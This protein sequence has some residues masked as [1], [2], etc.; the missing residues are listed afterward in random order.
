MMWRC[1]NKLVKMVT[2]QNG[3]VIGKEI[4]PNSAVPYEAL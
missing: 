1:I 3:L 4:S 2:A